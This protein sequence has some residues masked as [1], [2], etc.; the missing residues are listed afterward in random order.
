MNVNDPYSDY[1]DEFGV[2][3]PLPASDGQRMV[4]DEGFYTGPEV[5]ELLPGFTLRT[6]AGTKLD[7][8]RDRQKS[9]AALV[10]FRSAVW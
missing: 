6:A 2:T 7:L 1:R 4:P 5:G 3:G 9:K 8:H 10:F